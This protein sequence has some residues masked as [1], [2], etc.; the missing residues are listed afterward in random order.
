MRSYK[1]KLLVLHAAQVLVHYLKIDQL[2]ATADC[3]Q[4]RALEGSEPS[5]MIVHSSERWDAT[6]RDRGPEP[7]LLS[8]YSPKPPVFLESSISSFF[9]TYCVLE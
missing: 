6:S 8:S 2:S 1:Y 4:Q 5:S 9:F 7:V 3:C